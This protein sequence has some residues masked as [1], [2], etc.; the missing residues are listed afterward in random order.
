M[1]QGFDRESAALQQQMAA[2]HAAQWQGMLDRRAAARRLAG[3]R[4]QARDPARERQ[5]DEREDAELRARQGV[6][7]AAA[8]AVLA[9]REA[10]LLKEARS[11][12]GEH[13]RE[14]EALEGSLRLQRTT[15]H[16]ST[17]HSTHNRKNRSGQ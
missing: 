12:R 5:E 11:I 16:H 2:E 1:S 10:A 14:S 4:G 15:I 6:E 8:S 13:Q 7:R 3:L 17:K 9:E